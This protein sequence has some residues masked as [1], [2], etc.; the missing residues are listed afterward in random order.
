MSKGNLDIELYNI[1]K[2][3]GEQNNV[4]AD[5]PQVVAELRSMMETVRTPSQM[6]PLKP[7]DAPL[8]KNR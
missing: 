3:I 4:A 8:K 7:I 5:H 1:A 2:D 6:F